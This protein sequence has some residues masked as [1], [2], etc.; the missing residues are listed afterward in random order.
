MTVIYIRRDK[1]FLRR[2]FLDTNSFELIIVIFF[3]FQF[4]P[5][6]DLRGATGLGYLDKS[7]S[8]VSENQI[9]KLSFRPTIVC[10]SSLPRENEILSPNFS[11]SSLILK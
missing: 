7:D 4:A 9:R 10:F 6:D 2:T 5:Q 11:F 3:F 1:F 8:Q